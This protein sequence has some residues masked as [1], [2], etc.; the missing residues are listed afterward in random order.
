MWK[1]FD[2]MLHLPSCSCQAAKD[3]NDFSTLIKLM[4]FLMGLDDVYQSVRTNLLTRE[5]LPSVK[6]AFS[7]ISREESHRLSSSGSKTQSVSFVS[8]SN[9]SFDQRKKVNRGP[10]SNLKCTHCNML[11]HTVDRCFEIVGYPP[12]FKRRVNSN[13]QS[14]RVNL[15]SN[16]KTSS[17]IG[18]SSSVSGNGLPFT[19]E[20][21][22]KLL[23]LV[24]EKGESDSQNQKVGGE[25]FNV[26]NFVS[27][28]SSVNFSMN[29]WIV[30]SGASQHMVST[31]KNL[32]NF[33]DVSEFNITVGHPN[34]TSVKVLK[35]GD[36]K[37]TNDILLKDV[38]YV[39]GYCVNL[40]S[41]YKLS[42]D[43][44]VSVKFNETSCF[45]QDSSSKRI[46]MSGRQDCGLYFVGNAGCKVCRLEE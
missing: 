21:I 40:L 19:S 39:P 27:C 33:V 3:F 35:I 26:F 24:G 6:V 10:N 1:H 36:L 11:G 2:A 22:A 31:D 15:A 32:I 17:V 28:S 7:I 45:L 4:Q 23:S 46:L 13:N 30:D 16:N 44:H 42:K 9:Q 34:G 12:G 25:C 8:K 38:F 14:N 18:T 5:P 43:N 29:G 41:V 20:Q 37:L